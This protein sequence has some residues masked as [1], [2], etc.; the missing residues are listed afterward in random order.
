MTLFFLTDNIPIR[1][2]ILFEPVE[3]QNLIPKV[4]Y[5]IQMTVFQVLLKSAIGTVIFC[6]F[7]FFTMFYYWVALSYQV[8]CC[9]HT[10]VNSYL[11]GTQMNFTVSRVIDKASS[12]DTSHIYLTISN[13]LYIKWLNLERKIHLTVFLFININNRK[14]L[15]D[16]QWWHSLCLHIPI[17][18][19]WLLYCTHP[20]YS[21][22]CLVNY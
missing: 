2:F 10:V 9:L 17:L 18:F 4:L 20:L 8:K 22:G 21:D 16:L 14:D 19:F 5:F 3:V 6:K 15:L 12:T 13:I 7:H 11:M 1:R